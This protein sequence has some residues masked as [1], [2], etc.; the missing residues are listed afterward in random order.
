VSAITVV[1]ALLVIAGLVLTARAVILRGRLSDPHHNA[2]DAA[3][4]TLEP[5][6]KG[7]GFLAPTASWPGLI[8]V[9]AGALML[10]LPLI[11]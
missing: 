8:L 6:G 7:V 3:G 2:G 11:L 10:G 4:R 1:G 9:L 5:A